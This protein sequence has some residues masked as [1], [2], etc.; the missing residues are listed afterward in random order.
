MQFG[1]YSAFINDEAKLNAEIDD[2]LT[3]YVK[4]VK[5]SSGE[6]VSKDDVKAYFAQQ[7]GATYLRDTAIYELVLDFLA[8][9][10]TIDWDAA[11][12]QEKN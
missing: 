3:E 5:I 10:N 7:N 12:N 2:F 6:T 1:I 11:K 8:E 9:N 4:V